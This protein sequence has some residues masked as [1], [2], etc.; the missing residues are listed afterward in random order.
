MSLLARFGERSHR[1]QSGVFA[2][3]KVQIS[4]CEMQNAKCKIELCKI[5][6]QSIFDR[7]NERDKEKHATKT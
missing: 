3:C 2:K 4:K 6:G 1:R 7:N 5:V